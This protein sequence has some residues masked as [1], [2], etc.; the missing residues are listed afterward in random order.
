MAVCNAMRLLWQR[1]HGQRA[2]EDG[3][4]HGRVPVWV[5]IN[6][7]WRL[8]LERCQLKFGHAEKTT[9]VVGVQELALQSEADTCEEGGRVR[10]GHVLTFFMARDMRMTCEREHL[11]STMTT[12]T[13]PSS[14]DTAGNMDVSNT[15]GKGWKC[16]RV[17][18]PGLRIG[19]DGRA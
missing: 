2:V 7:E 14:G 8:G 12:P 15:P 10:G 3:E 9:L 13:L 1:K 5:A 19:K 16:T 11:P 17:M 6:V 4:V 18:E